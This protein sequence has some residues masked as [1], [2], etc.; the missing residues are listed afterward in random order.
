ME[1]TI[2]KE[3]DLNLIPKY[4]LLYSVIIATIVILYIASNDP[5][6]LTTNTYIYIALSI[7]PIL[8]II[9]YTIPIF[10]VSDGNTTKNIINVGLCVGLFLAATYFYLNSNKSY[11]ELISY[12]SGMIMFL[13]IIVGLALFYFLVSNYLKSF[14]GTSGFVVYFIFYIPCLL[15]D[16]FKYLL[17]EFKATSQLVYIL[18]VFEIVLILF[19]IFIPQL[20]NKIDKKDGVVLLEKG[21]FLDQSM[22]ISSSEIF[23]IPTDKLQNKVDDS[24][25]RKT[26]AFSMWVFLNIKSTSDAAYSKETTIFDCG[27]GK[28]KITYHN[29]TLDDNKKDKY[30]I[31]FTDIKKGPSSYELTLPNQKWN[32]FVFNYDSNKVDLFIN[33]ELVRTFNFKMNMPRVKVSDNITIGSDNGL[34]GAIC[35]IRYYPNNLSSGKIVSNYN[36]LMYKNP[37]VFIL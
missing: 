5:A 2:F 26:Y 14:T 25:Y 10:N 1:D 6:S 7:I 27:G 8:A 15:I 22:A 18:F 16:F 36:L 11:F 33:G 35:N 12:A 13:I 30:I 17:K 31:Y 9:Y 3:F 23:K 34:N 19:Y 37:P 20:I 4:A 29:N 21:A 28:P 32:N 24:V